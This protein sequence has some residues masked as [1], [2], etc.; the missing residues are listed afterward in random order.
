M[1]SSGFCRPFRVGK[2]TK[3][4]GLL[5]PSAKRMRG[6]PRRGMGLG[7]ALGRLMALSFLLRTPLALTRGVFLTGT[8]AIALMY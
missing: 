7:G 6:S 2:P 3:S 8:I 4:A 5:L 1:R